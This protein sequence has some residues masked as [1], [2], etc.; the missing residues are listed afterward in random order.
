MR[1]IQ[2]SVFD[3]HFIRYLIA[4]LLGLCIY[5][6]AC[7]I[8]STENQNEWEDILGYWKE[9]IEE[10]GIKN[11]TALRKIVINSKGKLEQ[12]IVYELGNQCR[13]WLNN[14]DISFENGLLKF[15]G[16]DFEG[17]I[18]A[19]KNSIPMIYKNMNSP[20]I[21][22]RLQDK[23]TIQFLDSI[24][25]C[26]DAEYIYE[27]PEQKNDNWICVDLETE[28]MDKNKLSG[29]IN[30]IK[31]SKY[32]D[33]HSLLIVR[34]GKLLLEE[35]FW[36]D[37]KI[38]GPFVNKIFRERIQNQASVTKSVNSALIG[39]AL[40]QGLIE[41]TKQKVHEYFPEHEEIFVDGKRQIQLYDLLTMSSGLQW[42]ELSLSYNNPGND[43]NK[44]ERS[45]DLI[46]YCLNKP[47]ESKPGLEFNY[48]SGLSIILGEIVHRASGIETNKYAE[49][50]LFNHLG[51]SDYS[52][53]RRK[54][55][56]LATGGGLALRARDMAKFGLLYLNSGKWN[57]EQILSK[58]FI[59]R[60]T[61]PQIKTRSGWYGFQWWIR[62]FNI[63]NREI[64][65][66]Y[67]N[68]RA[69]QFIFVFPE[70]KMIVVSTAQNYKGG[71]HK[72]FYKMLQKEILPALK[73]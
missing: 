18:S 69:G 33:I 73:Y 14:D 12:S 70:M 26:Q 19:D 65:A 5:I 50:N 7:N 67:A 35:Y 64:L 68:G 44:M 61:Q 17:Q 66:Y 43:V 39:L 29:L 6:S 46:K 62:S 71:Y 59:Q 57:G 32:D 20:F 1:F 49:D 63:R 54:N 53:S 58:N 52:W 47:L 31:K 48:N 22:E 72:K 40:K 28:G 41:D 55:N 56:L 51:I 10:D 45:D 30:Q 37:G 42:N 34:N 25:N 15:W 60:S 23:E 21:L 2:N 24:Q 16:D 8:N 13:I 11:E 4:I 36:A 38:A 3:K 27:I 9:Y